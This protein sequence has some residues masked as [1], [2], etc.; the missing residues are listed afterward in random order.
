MSFSLAH[1][2]TS[3]L[4]VVW[5]G[6]F[7]P[8]E[9]AIS[10]QLA[11]V[12]VFLF[13]FCFHAFEVPFSYNYSISRLCI[14]FIFFASF[15]AGSGIRSF[16][17]RSFSQINQDKWAAVSESLRSL[18]R[19]EWPWVNCSGRSGQ[20]SNHEQFAHVTHDKRE[21]E[22]IARFFEWIAHLLTKR[23]DS[24]QKNSLKLYFLVRFL[25]VFF[26]QAICSF[27]LF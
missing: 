20:K 5:R 22:L 1:W 19:N 3:W 17:H 25:K 18:K 9:G 21:K 4:A 2:I 16:T 24:L 14:P 7:V 11:V 27:S 13:Y 15:W 8:L 26:K 12:F 23:S 6:G 10:I